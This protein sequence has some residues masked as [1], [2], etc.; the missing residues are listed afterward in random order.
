M[1]TP[2]PTP[3]QAAADAELRVAIQK[4]V[5]AYDIIPEDAVISAWCVNILAVTFDKNGRLIE[6]GGYVLP[7]NG[8]TTSNTMI[9]GLTA[10]AYEFWKN[11]AL[12]PDEED[13]D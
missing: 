7:E 2:P 10:K 8:K 4:A 5:R 6:H 12:T 9:L 1:M 13:E 3:E 11:Q